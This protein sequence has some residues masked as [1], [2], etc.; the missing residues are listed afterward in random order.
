M[1]EISNP[2]VNVSFLDEGTGPTV[3]LLHSSGASSNQWRPLMKEYGDQY[4]FLAPD[5]I[6]GGST[7]SLC[8]GP[9]ATSHEVDVVEAIAGLVNE[10]IDLVGHS[11]GA[12]VAIDAAIVLG[13]RVNSLTVIE[14][15]K[16]QF[17]ERAG[18]KA[19]EEE[20]AEL[21]RTHVGLVER[22]KLEEAAIVFIDYWS[23][24]GLW[25]LL[26]AHVRKAIIH[27]MPKLADGFRALKMADASELDQLCKIQAP[28]HL[29]FGSET[30]LA[31]RT[32]AE[33]LATILPRAKLKEIKGVG[34]M[35]PLTNPEIV[36]PLIL[37]F[38]KSQRVPVVE[39]Q[40][41]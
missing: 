4:H 33:Y 39:D 20:I 18:N 19:A 31:A 6:G 41:I 16:F 5:L 14:P 2:I 27:D 38:I 29:L 30:T 36:N 7:R 13:D 22:G 40:L 24:P 17:L 8:K 34:H 21:S 3:V 10:P 28:V 12:A 15:V 37:D 9:F 26:P 1:K 35:S 23:G 32:V 11:Y 25:D